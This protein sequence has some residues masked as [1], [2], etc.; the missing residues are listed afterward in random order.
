MPVVQEEHSLLQ[1]EEAVEALDA[2]L[3]FKNNAI[4]ER[5]NHLF[6]GNSPLLESKDTEPAQHCDITRKLKKLSLPEAIELLIKY[7]NKARG[8]YLH[9]IF[10]YLYK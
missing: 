5:Q 6:V 3:E 10:N 2:A 1:L 7:F 9:H 4:Q 8:N